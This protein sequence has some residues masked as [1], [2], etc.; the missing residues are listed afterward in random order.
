[1]VK[2]ESPS[3]EEELYIRVW[4]MKWYFG[5]RGIAN[6]TGRFFLQSYSLE[7]DT[8]ALHELMNT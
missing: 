6:M 5:N 3:S 1:M 8:W 4:Y 7:Y 2:T